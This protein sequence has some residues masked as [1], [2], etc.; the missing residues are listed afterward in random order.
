VF[1]PVS[2]VAE[3]QPIEIPSALPHDLVSPPH[4]REH[5]EAFVTSPEP[6]TGFQGDRS[7]DSFAQ[8]DAQRQSE[9]QD[10]TSAEDGAEDEWQARS[11]LQTPSTLVEPP[12]DEE[13]PDPVAQSSGGDWAWQH[14][15]AEQPSSAKEADH[16]TN[17]TQPIRHA[18][19]DSLQ[20]V[21]QD[22]TDFS[23]ETVQQMSAAIVDT[24]PLMFQG[25]IDAS[26]FV[27][28]F[29]SQIDP[30]AARI[31]QLAIGGLMRLFLLHA[32]AELQGEQ[33]RLSVMASQRHLDN[34][35]NRQTLQQVLSASYGQP[36]TLDIIF[37]EQVPSC[38]V[39][40]QQQIDEARRRYVAQ[41]MATD[42]LVVA[43]QQHFAAELQAESLSVN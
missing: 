21:E 17:A 1:E 37:D 20:V 38:P 22:N 6:A 36:L 26:N 34:E 29:A 42:P 27:V 33:L 5:I 35:K 43:L 7:A 16:S 14:Y 12:N 13:E 15:Q 23:A 8:T 2:R 11:Y 4:R 31:D 40:I 18:L 9:L 41:V 39:A 3:I 28:K 32:S 10:S 30:W 24:Q 25:V 19:L